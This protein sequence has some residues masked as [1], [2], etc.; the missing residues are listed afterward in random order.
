MESSYD[1]IEPGPI[2]FHP[3]FGLYEENGSKGS[4]YEKIGYGERSG[5]SSSSEDMKSEPIPVRF[6][7]PG[8]NK[9]ILS[10]RLSRVCQ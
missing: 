9:C 10:S 3:W 7:I 1:S 4:L 6:S 2:I 5:R 8:L